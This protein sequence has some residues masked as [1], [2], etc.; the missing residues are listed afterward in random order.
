MTINF[1]PKPFFILLLFIGF[2]GL[3]FLGAKYWQ[4]RSRAPAPV[5]TFVIEDETGATHTISTTGKAIRESV[6]DQNL[7]LGLAEIETLIERGPY[8]DPA[9]R[10]RIVP[11]TQRHRIE[12]HVAPP[13]TS[14]EAAARAWLSDNRFPHIPDFKIDVLPY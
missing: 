13:E 12:L 8:S 4:F 2:V 5:S 11:N 10:F 14:N 7:D 1:S 3:G 6:A 9:G